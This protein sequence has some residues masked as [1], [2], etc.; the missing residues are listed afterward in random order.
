LTGGLGGSFDHRW[1]WM[2]TPERRIIMQKLLLSL[3][4]ALTIASLAAEQ[5]VVWG[6]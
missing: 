3:L 5:V 4:L 1:R 2:S 6:S